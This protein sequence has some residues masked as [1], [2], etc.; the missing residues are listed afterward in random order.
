MQNFNGE[1]YRAENDNYTFSGAGYYDIGKSEGVRQ[2][3]GAVPIN[4][5]VK[6]TVIM[7]WLLVRLQGSVVRLQFSEP[8]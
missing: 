1:T 3:K 7:K 4:E 6:Q 5:V 8:V 2:S